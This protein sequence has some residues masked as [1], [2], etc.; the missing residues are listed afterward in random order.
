MTTDQTNDRLM[1]AFQIIFI[2]L[3]V[4]LTIYLAVGALDPNF[5]NLPLKDLALKD[6]MGKLGAL[7]IIVL[8]VE[9][10]IELFVHPW[11][12]PKTES[13][14]M[15]LFTFSAE[16][17]R[18]R[19]PGHQTVDTEKKL[20]SHRSKT[21]LVTLLAGFVIGVFISI[22]GVGFLNELVHVDP[23]A[24]GEKQIPYLRKVDVVLTAGL[25]AG[26]SDGFH[27]FMKAILVFF[28]ETTKKMEGT[29]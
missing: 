29:A 8:L 25:I 21:R 16:G 26:G 24:V 1:K 27:Q 5:K 7:F 19:K 2:T 23:A 11:R 3:G 12:S 14:K 10:L 13:L 4:L 17:K 15:E 18:L 28:E 9:R 20:G 6:L 22:G